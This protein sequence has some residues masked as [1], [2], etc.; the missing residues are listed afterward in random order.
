MYPKEP[1]RRFCPSQSCTSAGHTILTT[2][3]YTI[4]LSYPSNE[5]PVHL[6]VSPQFSQDP[7]EAIRCWLQ[8]L[9][10]LKVSCVILD[11]LQVRMKV[12]LFRLQEPCPL[13]DLPSYYN[14]DYHKNHPIYAIKM[15]IV[16]LQE[17][18]QAA[19]SISPGKGGFP[20]TSKDKLGSVELTRVEEGIPADYEYDCAHSQCVPRCVWLIPRSIGQKSLPVE[21]LSFDGFIEPD[22]RCSHELSIQPAMRQRHYRMTR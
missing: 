17:S 20:L 5:C 7:H 4:P 18:S 2:L 10:L 21:T 6:S 11:L 9:L 16:S 8:V 22:P 13:D 12:H 3:F 19:G 1:L 14:R 15:T